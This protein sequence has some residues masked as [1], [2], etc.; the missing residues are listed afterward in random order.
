MS[1]ITEPVTVSGQTL[2][3]SH[4]GGPD[5]WHGAIRDD[6]GT[7]WVCPHRHRNRDESS[8]RSGVAAHACAALV[9]KCLSHPTFAEDYIAAINRSS[10]YAVGGQDPAITIARTRE[11]ERF[12]QEINDAR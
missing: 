7:V 6:K 2:R 3:V 5:G 12:A 11:A 8:L 9:L 10:Q 1:F 4:A